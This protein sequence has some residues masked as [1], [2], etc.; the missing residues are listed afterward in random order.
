MNK[1][2]I[3]KNILEWVRAI[4]AAF[5][6]ALLLNN[7]IIAH[8]KVISSSME[9]TIMTNSRVMGS[10]LSYIID[11][12]ERF[13]IILFKFPDDETSLPFVKR[14]I[15]LPNEKVEI[16]DGKVYIDDSDAPL[17]DS[18]IKEDTRGNYG[19]FIV[20]ENSYFVLGDNRNDSWDSK[21]WTN[22]FVSKDKILG[23][24]LVEY[25]PNPKVL[26]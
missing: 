14:I 25:F 24:I 4:A 8:A 1:K 11:E 6:I 5:V 16:I 7:A 26:N 19:P 12:P 9:S 2:A 13:D 23:K 17:D 21:N 20:P 15:G 10:R 22:K 18:F 3:M